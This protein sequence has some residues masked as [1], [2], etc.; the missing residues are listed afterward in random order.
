MAT[1]AAKFRIYPRPERTHLKQK[2]EYLKKRE[3]QPLSGRT[4]IRLN[5]VLRLSSVTSQF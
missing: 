1:R 4:G 5:F 3:T 2:L